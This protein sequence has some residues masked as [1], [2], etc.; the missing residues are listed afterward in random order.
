LNEWIEQS[1]TVRDTLVRLFPMLVVYYP[2]IAKQALS[3]LAQSWT[4]FVSDLQPD[5]SQLDGL[6]L[7]SFE[8]PLEPEYD[9][10]L[11]QFRDAIATLKNRRSQTFLARAL[12]TAFRAQHQNPRLSSKLFDLMRNPA[13]ARLF[14]ETVPKDLI[15]SLFPAMPPETIT[16]LLP[17]LF[18]DG[19]A[20]EINEPA[21][22]FAEL[23]EASPLES[24]LLAHFLEKE[25]VVNHCYPNED[26]S[27]SFVNGFEAC[28]LPPSLHW[29]SLFGEFSDSQLDSLPVPLLL[30]NS[31]SERG[32]SPL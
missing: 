13:V 10:I 19:L 28:V 27:V 32:R 26:L 31:V 30:H 7:Y 5:Y 15:Q 14:C 6:L 9:T 23:F 20:P 12:T 11:H 8:Y 2:T 29:N 17:H 25:P 24:I 16:A 3:K 4:S 18:R 22:K 1:L 21:A